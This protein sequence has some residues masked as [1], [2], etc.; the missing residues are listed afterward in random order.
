MKI[1]NTR[2]EFVVSRT[3]QVEKRLFESSYHPR[4]EKMRAE[5]RKMEKEEKRDRKETIA[6]PHFAKVTYCIRLLNHIESLWSEIDLFVV[7]DRSRVQSP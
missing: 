7:G 4:F 3:R 5:K 2:L 6:Y 1:A